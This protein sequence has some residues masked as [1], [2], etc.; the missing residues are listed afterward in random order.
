VAH[1]RD[2]YYDRP[3]AP[4]SWHGRLLAGLD[5]RAGGHWLAVRDDGAFALVT[6]YRTGKAAPAGA[7]S[8]GLLVPEIL[9]GSLRDVAIPEQLRRSSH[10]P[11]NVIYGDREAQWFFSNVTGQEESLT[12]PVSGL[13]NALLDTPWPKVERG[14][15][16]V[17][18][19]LA[20]GD[21]S[22][23]TQ[24]LFAILADTW[25]PAETD[26]PATGVS[27]LW[28]RA[29]GPIFIRTP[30]YGTR[31]STVI[32]FYRDGSI[33]FAERSFPGPESIE[34]L[35]RTFRWVPGEHPG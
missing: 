34:P 2:E 9:R 11:F 32:L 30:T 3:A 21:R 16:L 27:P 5:L 29:L 19:L 35:T 6:N 17:R 15:A 8:R 24:D 7:R 25:Q 33:E 12:G 28:E 10:A 31:A 20:S 1:N 23:L 13:S 26:L 14:K 18:A 22:E 4:A